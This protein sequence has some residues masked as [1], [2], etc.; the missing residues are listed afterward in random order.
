LGSVAGFDDANAVVN[1]IGG[2][3]SDHVFLA[4]AMT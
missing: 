3:I 2:T 1:N 4:K